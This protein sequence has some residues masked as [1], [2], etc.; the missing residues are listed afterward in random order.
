MATAGR[1]SG[2]I[3]Q[4]LRWLGKHSVD[5]QTTTILKERLTSDEKA[6]LLKDIHYTPIGILEIIR[7]VA[8]AED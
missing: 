7:A 3:I 2:T 5:E 6:I 4:A 8:E 1:I